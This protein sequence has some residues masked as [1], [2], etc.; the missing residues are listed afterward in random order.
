MRA[1]RLSVSLVLGFAFVASV[2]LTPSTSRAD[3]QTYMQDKAAYQ[4]AGTNFDARANALSAF[5]GSPTGLDSWVNDVIKLGQ[6]FDATSHSMWDMIYLDA[7][8]NNTSYCDTYKAQLDGSWGS[9]YGIIEMID[10]YLVRLNALTSARSALEA[11][12]SKLIEKVATAASDHKTDKLASDQLA[13]TRTTLGKLDG[14]YNA[15]LARY[16]GL[17]TNKQATNTALTKPNCGQP[18]PTPTPTPPPTPKPT[19][20]PT[21]KPTP[22]PTPT[23]RPQSIP[24]GVDRWE[25][26]WIDGPPNTV[27]CGGDLNSGGAD[28]Q[29]RCVVTPKLPNGLNITVEGDFTLL[30]KLASP[31]TLTS[32]CAVTGKWHETNYDADLTGT[33]TLQYDYGRHGIQQN[34]Q[35]QRDKPTRMPPM[36]SNGPLVAVWGTYTIHGMG[37]FLHT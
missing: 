21:P 36:G 19:P 3:Q 24:T 14:L 13:A 23:A 1:A 2:V 20:P 10:D 17:L 12:E 35:M 29:M 9:R 37:V 11:S 6:A 34:W 15:M 28:L 27:S 4:T 5:L 32:T 22:T 26:T 30:C 25:G 33:V 18:T 7:A 8:R 16:N 31:A